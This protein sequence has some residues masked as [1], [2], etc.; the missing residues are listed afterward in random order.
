MTGLTD[1]VL[2]TFLVSPIPETITFLQ[3]F[4]VVQSDGSYQHRG[5]DDGMDTRTSPVTGVTN[6]V[7]VEHG[8]TL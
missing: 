7:Q 5:D 3:Q 2:L 1:L 4:D 6:P 8:K